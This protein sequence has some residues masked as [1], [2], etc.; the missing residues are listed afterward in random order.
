MAGRKW[1]AAWRALG[2]ALLPQSCQLC[3]GDA[4]AYALCAPCAAQ[5]PRWPALACPCCALPT[6]RGT[7]CGRCLKARPAFDHSLAVFDYAFPLDRLVQALKYGKQ[8]SLAPF[9]GGE[10]AA[11]GAH[12]GARI[13]CILPMPLHPRRLAERGFNQAV[14]LARPLARRTAVPLELAAVTKRRDLAAQASLAR[15]QRLR[16]PRAAFACE[17]ALDGLRIL[18]I[19]DVMTTGATLDALA[20]CLKAAG[21]A[22]VGNLVLA[23]TPLP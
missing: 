13:D 5:L 2:S 9:L 8:L 10:L 18:V 1:R 7:H 14:E 3:G 22:W 16:A 12:F 6:V 17:R 19:D 4:G 15:A 21:A 11:A 23:R 20:R